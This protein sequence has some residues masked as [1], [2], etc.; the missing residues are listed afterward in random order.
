MRQITIGKEQ[1]GQR[2][3][4]FLGKYLSLAP[5]SF[6][7]KMLRKKNIVL[8]GKKADGSEKIQTGD[9]V[10][11]FLSEATI[12]K[13]QEIDKGK[14]I[15]ADRALAEALSVLYED[16]HILVINKPA[17][18]LSQKA[19]REDVSLVEY[20]HAY[21]AADRMS[22]DI[23][24]QGFKPGICNRLDRNTSGIIVAGKTMAGLQTMNQLFKERMLKK[25]YLCIVKGNIS[26][27]QD[28][29]GYLT[30]DEKRN[31]VHISKKREKGSSYI[32]TGYEPLA[33]GEKDGTAYTLLKV[34]L[35]TGK[36]HQIRAHLQS[37]GHPIVGDMKYGEKEVWNYFQKK[38][39]LKHQLLHSW[40]LELPV[41]EGTL[42]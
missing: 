27:K 16:E 1:A 21:L 12:E 34:H 2:F 14:P 8:N 11:F 41:I 26:E 18:M 37:M 39:Q 29:E 5:K 15:K 13:F 4:K 33:T 38:Y 30:K 19:Q 22:D 25:Y 35:I 23:N 3:D 28:I 17:E 42:S 31:I 20:L 40:R 7:Y 24:R 6:I 10:K 36:S 9:E 32:Q